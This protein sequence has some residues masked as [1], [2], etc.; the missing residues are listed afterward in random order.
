LQTVP[1]TTNDPITGV[2]LPAPLP[3]LEGAPPVTFP[4]V[5]QAHRNIYE[6]F[7]DGTYIQWDAYSRNYQGQTVPTAS[8]SGLFAPPG[9]TGLLNSNFELV[10]TASEFGGRSIDLVVAPKALVQTGLL[11]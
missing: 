1:A 9:A 3:V 6:S 7:S 10:I 8:P 11:P 4:D 2:L 5:G